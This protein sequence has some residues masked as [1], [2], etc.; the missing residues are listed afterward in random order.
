MY[1]LYGNISYN[2]I[3]YHVVISELTGVLSQSRLS[4]SQTQNN[5]QMIKL[6]LLLLLFC[7]VCQLQ[8]DFCCVCNKLKR[9]TITT[10]GAQQ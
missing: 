3:S 10:R 9:E 1:S 2:H 4:A 8:F 5:L 6:L 7:H